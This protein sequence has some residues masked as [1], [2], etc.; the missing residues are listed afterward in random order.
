M[1]S[2]VVAM[3]ENGLIGK[4][5][6]IPWHLPDDLKRFKKIT[7][8][9]SIVMGRKTFDSIGKPLPGR[10]NIV[11]TRNKNAQLPGCTVFYSEDELIDYCRKFKDEIFVI[12]GSGLFQMF[13]PYVDRLYITRIYET[14]EG[15]V[16]FPEMDLST[17]EIIE[18]EKGPK[19][20]KNPF[21]Y[22][23]I[24]YERKSKI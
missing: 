16:Y 22:E 14:F 18:S 4:N 24:L 12:G 21:D 5:N 8:G 17:F 11:L 6:Q 7:M 9:H 2:F 1:I 20:E 10:E 19:D 3:D 13:S 23:Y 15:D